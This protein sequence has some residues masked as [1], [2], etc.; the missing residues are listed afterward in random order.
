MKKIIVSLIILIGIFSN[1]GKKSK[2]MLF[3]SDSA[4]EIYYN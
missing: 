4:L 3:N 2:E 1:C